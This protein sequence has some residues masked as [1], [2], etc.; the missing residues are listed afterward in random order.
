MTNISKFN[1]YQ[2]KSLPKLELSIIY[3]FNYEKSTFVKIVFD[4]IVAK[5]I[6]L[7]LAFRE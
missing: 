4:V 7:L 6:D 1:K 5:V 2:H 3:L